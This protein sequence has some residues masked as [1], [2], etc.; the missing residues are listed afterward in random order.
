MGSKDGEEQGEDERLS[1][2]SHSNAQNV[3]SASSSNSDRRSHPLDDDQEYRLQSEIEGEHESDSESENDEDSLF[4]GHSGTAGSST[5]ILS[6]SLSQ[7]P[8]ATEPI[9][10]GIDD[11]RSMVTHDNLS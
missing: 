5:T 7:Q 10:E 6:T 3:S 1:T 8:I 4:S 2:S 11:G 9:Y